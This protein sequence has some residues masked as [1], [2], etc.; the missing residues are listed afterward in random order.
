[1]RVA[2]KLEIEGQQVGEELCVVLPWFAGPDCCAEEAEPGDC[3]WPRTR[4]AVVAGE[5]QSQ[6]DCR[7]RGG[8]GRRVAADEPGIREG[9]WD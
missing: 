5:E 1:M 9:D 4:L 3:R 8:R 2:R 6:G 7:W